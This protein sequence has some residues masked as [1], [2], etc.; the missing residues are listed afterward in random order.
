MF[1]QT[2]LFELFTHLFPIQLLEFLRAFV[3]FFLTIAFISFFAT[4]RWHNMK[5]KNLEVTN[6][7]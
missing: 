3:F 1:L 7:L 6:F 2:Q 4:V 5:N